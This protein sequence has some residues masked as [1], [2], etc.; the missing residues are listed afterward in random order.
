MLNGIQTGQP[1]FGSVAIEDK[2]INTYTGFLEKQGVKNPRFVVV[3]NGNK[4]SVYVADNENKPLC[5][6]IDNKDGTHTY[7]DLRGTA[8]TVNG[9]F[10]NLFEKS[11]KAKLILSR[12]VVKDLPRREIPFPT[13]FDTFG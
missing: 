5:T 3:L 12:D 2:V 1:A 7:H 10:K 4:T 13:K 11:K 6:T 9:S 8:K